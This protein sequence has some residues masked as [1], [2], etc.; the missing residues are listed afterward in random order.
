MK[1]RLDKIKGDVM[2]SNDTYVL[3]DNNF[4]EHLT[5]SRT[6][7]NPGMSTRGHSHDDQEE[8]YIFTKGKGNMVIGETTYNAMPN[9][10]FLIPQ[11]QF[12]RVINQSEDD[13][14]EFTC[15]FEKY[16]RSGNEAVYYTNLN[17]V[18]PKKERKQ[19]ILQRFCKWF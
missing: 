4:L 13:V 3:E 12:H 17:K 2:V 6:S 19:N 1:V 14:C 8:I 7:L 9:D 10:T 15:V 5:L 16:D 18:K 11:G